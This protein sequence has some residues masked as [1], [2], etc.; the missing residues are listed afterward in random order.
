M[1]KH[2]CTSEQL[3]RSSWDNHFCVLLCVST[4][5]GKQKVGTGA[6]ICQLHKLVFLAVSEFARLCSQKVTGKKWREFPLRGKAPH[7]GCE[8]YLFDELV[9]PQ[10]GEG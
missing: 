6:L 1:F 7:V 9:D 10:V 5:H 2:V 8:C 4:L 3:H